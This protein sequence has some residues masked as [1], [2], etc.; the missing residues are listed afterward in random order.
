ML[1]DGKYDRNMYC[2]FKV[3]IIIFVDDGSTY[4]NFNGPFVVSISFKKKKGM[5][6]VYLYINQTSALA[7]HSTGFGSSVQIPRCSNHS[8][9]V[10]PH[11]PNYQRG[12]KITVARR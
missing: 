8:R 4:V 10:G 5:P 3:V 1:E 7:E 12:G 9:H 2:M 6:E 11:G